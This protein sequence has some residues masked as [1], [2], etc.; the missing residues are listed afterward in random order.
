LDNFHGARRTNEHFKG[1]IRKY[2]P[3]CASFEKLTR[4]ELIE[5]ITVS[6]N[7]ARKFLGCAHPAE[8]F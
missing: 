5:L 7:P 3:K 2:L 6:N 8:A 1:Q 4:T